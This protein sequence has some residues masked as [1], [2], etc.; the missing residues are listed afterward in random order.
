M[1]KTITTI[2]VVLVALTSTAQ[3]TYRIVIP[4][5]QSKGGPLP[6]G[7]INIQSK[8]Q[9]TPIEEKPLTC[10][11]NQ[12]NSWMSD[13]GDANF[14]TDISI[15]KI[16]GLSQIGGGYDTTKVTL[17]GVTYTRGTTVKYIGDNGP[18]LPPY[19]FYEVCM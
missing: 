19:Y 18:E 8:A 12:N 7:S 3:A 13:G 14:P 17:N 9:T 1:K 4:M 2:A 5:E 11:F 15:I 6:N 16:D 10:L